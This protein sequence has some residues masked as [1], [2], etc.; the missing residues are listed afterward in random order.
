MLV[1]LPQLVFGLDSFFGI[2]LKIFSIELFCYFLKSLDMHALLK[3]P[4]FS[5]REI[6][7]SNLP[8]K[9]FQRTMLSLKF[10]IS[11]H[12][13]KQLIQISSSGFLGRLGDLKNESHFLKKATFTLIVVLFWH[14]K[15]E[16]FLKKF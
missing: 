12:I 13:S 4:F 10:E 1:F 6:I 14:E 11:A 16:R 7:F 5:E 2:F 15:H 9:L 3:V 8:K